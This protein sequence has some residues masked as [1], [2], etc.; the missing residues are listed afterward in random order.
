MYIWDGEEV[1]KGATYI[2]HNGRGKEKQDLKQNFKDSFFNY[3]L[4]TIKW[5][6][7]F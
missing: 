2:K 7:H 4:F 1:L 5:M 6:L 3:S